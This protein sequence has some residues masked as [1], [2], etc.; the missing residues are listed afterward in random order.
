MSVWAQWIHILIL[1]PALIVSVKYGF[2]M[3]YTSRALIRLTT[4]IINFVIMYVV[5][6]ISPMKMIKNVV[7]SCSAAF[8]M[9]L[10]S[11]GLSLLDTSMLWSL[12]SIAIC[13]FVYLGVILC[14][15][16]ERKDLLYLFV[17]LKSKI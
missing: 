4:V 11:Y 2:E 1:W 5:F 16:Q 17:N 14:F 10:A 6:K 8:L 9:A 3:L 7:V 13:I 15:P 12:V